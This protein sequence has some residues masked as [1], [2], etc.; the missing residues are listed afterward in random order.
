[1]VGLVAHG[2]L[3]GGG[4]RSSL[5]HFHDLRHPGRGVVRGWPMVARE[6]SGGAAGE[7]GLWEVDAGRLKTPIVPS[8]RTQEASDASAKIEPPTRR[9]L[10]F[11]ATDSLHNNGL[12]GTETV[13]F[14]AACYLNSF[15]PADGNRKVIARR[16]TRECD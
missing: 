14:E 13:S 9:G 2:R 5:G 1:A 11:Q 16:A 7:R 4:G 15:S 8:P 10:D 6:P 12:A 3:D